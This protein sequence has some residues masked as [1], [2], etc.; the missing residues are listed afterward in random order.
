[1]KWR[2]VAFLQERKKRSVSLLRQWLPPV[3]EGS[4]M[5]ISTPNPLSLQGELDKTEVGNAVK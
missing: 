4:G 1:M 3:G 2:G 5:G